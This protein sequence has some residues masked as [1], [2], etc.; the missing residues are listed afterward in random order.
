M[1]QYKP[2]K[3]KVYVENIAKECGICPVCNNHVSLWTV[4]KP[5]L[6]PNRIKCKT[7]KK[8]LKLS[9]P[10]WTFIGLQAA[11]GLAGV[12]SVFVA[13]WIAK[14]SI[15]SEILISLE[16]YKSALPL[17][18]IV[19]PAIILFFNYLAAYYFRKRYPLQER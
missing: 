3:S 18:L 14:I 2:P 12:F 5:T 15:G 17:M 19:S 16:V 11:G 9:I 1:D 4:G 13:F 6:V 7:C 10:K 8:F